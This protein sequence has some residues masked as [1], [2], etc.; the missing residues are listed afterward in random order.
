MLETKQ[1]KLKEHSHREKRELPGAGRA[2]IDKG[3][4]SVLTEQAKM[5]ELGAERQKVH[6]PHNVSVER[7]L[8]L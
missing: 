4:T 3:Y 1:P 5:G 8:Y 2:Q 7:D 6:D